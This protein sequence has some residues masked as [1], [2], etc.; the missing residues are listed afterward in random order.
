MSISN[1]SV[2]TDLVQVGCFKLQHLMDS[3]SVD[4]IGCL[5]DLD[6]CSVSPTKAGLDELLAILVEEVECW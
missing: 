2:K 4:L 3:G 6:R 1:D 5:S